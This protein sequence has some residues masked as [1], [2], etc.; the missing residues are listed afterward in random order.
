MTR[1][2]T[3]WVLFH[4]LATFFSWLK[5]PMKMAILGVIF[6]RAKKLHFNAIKLFCLNILL[7]IC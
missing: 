5:S 1:F 3:I 7:A 6:K 2:G 4:S